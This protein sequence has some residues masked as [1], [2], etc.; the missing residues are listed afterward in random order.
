MYFNNSKKSM[1]SQKY[2]LEI[3]K[4][5]LIFSWK[6]GKISASQ[7]EKNL[8]ELKKLQKNLALHTD[9]MTQKIRIFLD[10]IIGDIQEGREI[11]IDSIEQ[12]EYIENFLASEELTLQY[13]SLLKKSAYLRAQEAFE[14]RDMQSFYTLSKEIQKNFMETLGKINRKNFASYII[15]I[16]EFQL[17]KPEK[18]LRNLYHQSLLWADQKTAK[19]F[20]SLLQEFQV[21]QFE[22]QQ[23]I[24]ILSEKNALEHLYMVC[25]IEKNKISFSR[26]DASHGISPAIHIRELLLWY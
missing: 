6:I 1:Y 14:N 21:F 15:I 25:D 13:N 3:A 16:H 18:Y 12:D 4:K 10:D 22:I 9:P 11:N 26:V 20:L 2:L 19:I 7:A 5:L 8:Q 24:L 23:E 17:A